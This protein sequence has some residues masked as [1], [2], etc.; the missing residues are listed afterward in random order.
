MSETV[1]VEI[2]A[3]TSTCE[4]FGERLLQAVAPELAEA[5]VDP[6]Q[7]KLHSLEVEQVGY[8]EK[9]IKVKPR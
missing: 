4:D 3:S 6:E 7:V 2:G 1:T 9:E 8:G 5:G